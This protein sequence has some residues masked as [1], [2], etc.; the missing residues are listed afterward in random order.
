M[1]EE[2]KISMVKLSLEISQLQKFANIQ[3][4]YIILCHINLEICLKIKV[5]SST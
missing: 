1:K 3:R 4:H 5:Y 2:G